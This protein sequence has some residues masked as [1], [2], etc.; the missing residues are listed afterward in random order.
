MRY[1][2]PDTDDFLMKYIKY[3]QKNYHLPFEDARNFYIRQAEQFFKYEAS[4]LELL[5]TRCFNGIVPQASAFFY[6]NYAFASVMEL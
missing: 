4:F 1:C 5:H 3:F 6:S 2:Q